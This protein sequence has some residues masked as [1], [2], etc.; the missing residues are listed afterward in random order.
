M[1][2]IQ[3][4]VLKKFWPMAL[5]KPTRGEPIRDRESFIISSEK[6]SHIHLQSNSNL[7]QPSRLPRFPCK[8][9]PDFRAIFSRKQCRNNSITQPR[10]LCITSRKS[11]Q[12]SKIVPEKPVCNLEIH[13]CPFLDFCAQIFLEN[14]AK[15]VL[16][17]LQ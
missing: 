6:K 8:S 10:F 5:E 1:H 11:I 2:A 7:S 17:D 9:C 4:T 16:Y 12:S 3:N 13:V 15:S 14:S